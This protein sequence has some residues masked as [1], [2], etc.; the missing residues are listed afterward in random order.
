MACSK[1]VSKDS[2]IKS[3]ANIRSDFYIFFYQEDS[4]LIL[5]VHYPKSVNAGLNTAQLNLAIRCSITQTQ[6]IVPLQTFR[7]SP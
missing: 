6:K 7:L 1:I 3:N 5:I 2:N 4:D